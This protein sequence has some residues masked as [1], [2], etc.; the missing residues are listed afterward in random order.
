MTDRK[1]DEN[2]EVPDHLSHKNRLPLRSDENFLKRKY[3]YDESNLKQVDLKEK[4]KLLDQR[5]NRLKTEF[6]KGE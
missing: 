4:Y 5:L 3:C 6:K 1:G 2:T